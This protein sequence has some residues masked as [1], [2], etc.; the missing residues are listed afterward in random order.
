[1]SPSER[2]CKLG[3]HLQE[4][5]RLSPA[6][7]EEFVRL[8]VWRTMSTMIEEL[9]E[10][11][12]SRGK[13]PP[14]FWLQDVRALIA[15]TRQGALTPVAELYTLAGGSQ[16]MQH[17]LVQLGQMLQYWPVMVE[18]ARRLRSEGYRLAQLL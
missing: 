1:G 8:H 16:S 15:Q 14:A 4:L 13:P 12:R 11:R 10:Q 9:E 17:L 6:S 7:F 3:R 5:G 18:T 2:V